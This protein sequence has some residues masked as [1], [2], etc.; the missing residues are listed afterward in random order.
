MKSMDLTPDGYS[1]SDTISRLH[2][3][4][5]SG[6]MGH[7]YTICS[8]GKNEELLQQ[9]VLSEKDRIAILRALNLD[10]YDGWE[11]SDNLNH[12]EDIVHFFHKKTML[13]PR[14]VEDAPAQQ[15][16][17]YIKLTWE[18]QRCFMVIIS[19]HEMEKF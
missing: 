4:I 7:D 13:I 8:R 2:R 6:T 3:T 9:F 14:G 15:V 17:L 12:P 11:Q 10:D 16:V 1:P 5:D 18:Y 19:F